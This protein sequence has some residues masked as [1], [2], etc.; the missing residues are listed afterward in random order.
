ML[1]VLEQPGHRLVSRQ[2]VLHVLGHVGVLV[3]GRIIAVVCVVDLYIAHP[4]LTQAASAQ[5]VAPEIVRMLLTDAIHGKGVRTFLGQ[6][7]DVRC[8]VLHTP[9]KLER[10]DDGLQPVVPGCT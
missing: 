1:E 3:P 8:V 9:G 10:I 4:G 6:V 5:A 7:E 2:R